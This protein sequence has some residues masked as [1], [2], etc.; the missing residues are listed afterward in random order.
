[1]IGGIADE[2]QKDIWKSAD[3]LNWT[4]VTDD[5]PFGKRSGHTTLIFNNHIYLIAGRINAEVNSTDRP[6]TD[7]D[8]VI[9]KNYSN[10]VWMSEDAQSWT[11]LTPNAGFA[12]RELHSSF[13]F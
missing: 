1:M 13:E 11:Q 9:N 4:L 2:I 5:A 8:F 3:G 12:S 7:P 10:D 6:T